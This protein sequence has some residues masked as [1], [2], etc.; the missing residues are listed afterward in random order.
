MN[1]EYTKSLK[2]LFE[3]L[4]DYSLIERR[5]S[6]NLTEVAQKLIEEEISKRGITK[7]IEKILSEK[8]KHDQEADEALARKYPGIWDRAMAHLI[9]QFMLLPIGFLTAVVTDLL[10]GAANSSSGL[11]LIPC[12]LY[13]LFSDAL[14]NGQSIGKKICKIAVVDYKTRRPSGMFESFVRNLILLLAGYIDLFFIFSEERRRLGD[15]AA[16]TIVVWAK[17]VGKV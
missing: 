13:F 7:D 10:S 3:S 15:R 11:W 5:D 1:D 17:D 16:G 14:P 6:G 2:E 8:E 9:D 4:D 12:L